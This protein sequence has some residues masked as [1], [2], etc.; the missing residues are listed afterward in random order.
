MAIGASIQDETGKELAT[1]SELFGD[2]TNN[3]AEYRAVLAGLEKA[4]SLGATEI[5]VRIDSKLAV[6]QLNGRYKVKNERLKALHAQ[7]IEL[8]S[9]F[10]STV[11]HVPREQ[12]QR[13]D[14]LAN[15]AYIVPN[16]QAV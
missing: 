13:A 9:N 7:A 11:M 8:L 6:E 1:V 14:E 4:K 2:G 5:E 16:G 15:L 3:I 10:Q 12:N